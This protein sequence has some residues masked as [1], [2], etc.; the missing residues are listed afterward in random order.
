MCAHQAM[1]GSAVKVTS[2]SVCQTPVTPEDRTTASSSPT[3]TD[4]NVALDT[5][6]SVVTK[7]LTAVKEGPAG[8]EEHVLL[9]VTHLMVSSANV[10]LASPAP[11]VSMTLA[12]VGV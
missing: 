8:M 9:P 10:L 7:C 12:H 4:V 6:V 11:P 1:L 2:T 3:A 5:Q